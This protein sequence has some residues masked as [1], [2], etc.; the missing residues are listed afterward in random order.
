MICFGPLSFNDSN[1]P[2]FGAVCNCL[3]TSNLHIALDVPGARFVLEIRIYHNC[4]S[5]NTYLCHYPHE[6]QRE[7]VTNTLLKPAQKK[8]QLSFLSCHFRW[9]YVCEIIR[10]FF[11][12]ITR[13]TKSCFRMYQG[14]TCF[15]TV[16]VGYYQ[17][18]YTSVGELNLYQMNRN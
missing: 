16:C 12:L 11:T 6:I 7:T 3:Q 5:R 14:P 18:F 15:L 1:L 8:A 9:V 17:F 13:K 2:L 4:L 10:V